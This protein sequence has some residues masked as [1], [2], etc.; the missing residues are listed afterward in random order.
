M[1]LLTESDTLVPTRW[2]AAGASE[3]RSDKGSAK[4]CCPPLWSDWSEGERQLWTPFRPRSASPTPSSSLHSHTHLFLAFPAILSPFPA[5]PPPPSSFSLA[6]FFFFPSPSR[7]T[8]CT[9]L[10]LPSF[11]FSPVLP[12]IC[13][14]QWL[15][16]WL[17]AV[18]F[19]WSPS[20]YTV[21]LDIIHTQW[22]ELST[23][24]S[25][26][27]AVGR[28]ESVPLCVCVCEAAGGRERVGGREAVRVS[29]PI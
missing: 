27:T 23:L 18:W 5:L 17:A 15:C 2:P 12:S 25:T 6:P 29:V 28:C 3:I 10:L 26:A 9:D 13:L 24:G 7:R 20:E 16:L 14:I 8:Y 21:T 4:V 11:F 19:L 22:M 1:W